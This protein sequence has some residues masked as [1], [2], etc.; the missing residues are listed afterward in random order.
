MSFLESFV[1]FHI[2]RREFPGIREVVIVLEVALEVGN[3]ETIVHMDESWN[4]LVRKSRKVGEHQADLWIASHQHLAYFPDSIVV[5][6]GNFLEVSAVKHGHAPLNLVLV[7]RIREENERRVHSCVGV[8]LPHFIQSL[9]LLHN[10]PHVVIGFSDTHVQFIW[11]IV[12]L[13]VYISQHLVFLCLQK[14]SGG[15]LCD[16]VLA[17][18]FSQFINHVVMR[19]WLFQKVLLGHLELHL[20]LIASV[21]RHLIDIV[22]IILALFFL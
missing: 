3:F 8:Q 22:F 5:L 13:P 15:V 6:R 19:E 20:E 1:R 2:L 4:S 7:Q 14:S 9:T 21:A 17:Q 18:V 11:D 12:V 10:H 16:V